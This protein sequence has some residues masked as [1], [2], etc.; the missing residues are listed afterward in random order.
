MRVSL[1]KWCRGCSSTFEHVAMGTPPPLPHSL[2]RWVKE[3]GIPICQL[4]PPDI[5]LHES[6]RSFV[7]QDSTYSKNQKHRYLEYRKLNFEFTIHLV[8]EHFTYGDHLCQC[9]LRTLKG[10]TNLRWD[11]LLQ[12]SGDFTHHSESIHFC[13]RNNLGN[14][15]VFVCVIV[16]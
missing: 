5:Y 14:R 2:I 4:I 15:L 6:F 13:F 9:I 10:N 8:D 3:R 7:T 16:W 11:F 12:Y 1:L